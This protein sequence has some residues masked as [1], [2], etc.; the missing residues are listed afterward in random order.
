MQNHGFWNFD[1]W[2]L[3]RGKKATVNY[4]LYEWKQI[5]I[6]N[7]IISLFPTQYFALLVNLFAT[8]RQ[9]DSLVEEKMGNYLVEFCKQFLRDRKNVVLCTINLEAAIK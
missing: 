6:K 9:S 5:I 8:L 4:C 7:E 3:S 1:F 2:F